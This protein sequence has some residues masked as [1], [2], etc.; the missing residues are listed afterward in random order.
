MT[1]SLAAVLQLNRETRN[2]KRECP[3]MRHQQVR[4]WR[5]FTGETVHPLPDGRRLV[6]ELDRP[7]KVID[8]EGTEISPSP[9]ELTALLAVAG[10]AFPKKAANGKRLFRLQIKDDWTVAA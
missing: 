2:S 3:K 8:A 10:M 1:D 7:A 6:T 4:D 5:P 9:S